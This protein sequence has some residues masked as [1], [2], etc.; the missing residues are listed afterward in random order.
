M[1]PI[2]TIYIFS[3]KCHHSYPNRFS[4]SQPIGSLYRLTTVSLYRGLYIFSITQPICSLYRLT[5][6]SLYRYLYRKYIGISYKIVY[7][8]S[9]YFGIPSVKLDVIHQHFE[10][11]NI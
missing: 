11:C 2:W 5:T 4:I 6:V 1:V 7:K 3:I 10:K 8:G 9:L